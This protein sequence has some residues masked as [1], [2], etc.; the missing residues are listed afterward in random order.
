MIYSG[1]ELFS[2]TF[3][4]ENIF[5]YKSSN[6]IKEVNR[7]KPSPSVIVPW[8]GAELINQ[9]FLPKCQLFLKIF[10][11]KEFCFASTNTVDMV[12]NNSATTISIKALNLITLTIKALS[13]TQHKDTNTQ[14]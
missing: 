6:L 2:Y 10:F 7:T 14:Q 3:Y 1:Q 5:L 13:I 8:F 12:A 9:L 11:R 4:T